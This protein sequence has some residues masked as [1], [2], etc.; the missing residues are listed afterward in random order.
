MCFLAYEVL[1]CWDVLKVLSFLKWEFKSEW[2]KEQI[3]KC[4]SYSTNVAGSY[5]QN[6]FQIYAHACTLS[7]LSS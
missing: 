6:L 5:K 4:C 1:Q 7:A 2:P 3:I